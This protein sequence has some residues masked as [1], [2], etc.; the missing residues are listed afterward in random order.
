MENN[1][2]GDKETLSSTEPGQL[3]NDLESNLNTSARKDSPKAWETQLYVFLFL[4]NLLHAI[5][6]YFYF[7]LLYMKTS[8]LCKIYQTVFHHRSLYSIYFTK[9]NNCVVSL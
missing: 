5:S 8:V 7:T 4:F 3:Y 6:L 2:S 1:K 9:K